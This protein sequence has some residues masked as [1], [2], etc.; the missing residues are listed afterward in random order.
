MDEGRKRVLLIAASILAARN[1]ANWDGK[2]SPAVEA[3]IA[4][5]IAA[6]ERIMAKI[7]S[8]WPLPQRAGVS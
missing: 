7:D 6:A 2:P 5:A 3:A 4:N 8:R 1:L